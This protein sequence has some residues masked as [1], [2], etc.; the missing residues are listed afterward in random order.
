MP[1][2]FHVETQSGMAIVT[3]S[4]ELRGSD[5][6]EGVEA[7][8]KNPDWAGKSA[9]WDFRTAKF[10]ITATE[11]QELADF[12]LSNQRDTPP[13]R[14]A[15]VTGRDVDFGLARMFEAFRS[16]PRTAFRV[17]RNFD[18]ALRW[19]SAGDSNNV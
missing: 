11:V 19:A 14:V 4:G 18:K 1:V 17:F 13:E 2:S 3:C 6:M 12:V 8:W 16:D 7:L 15:F 5:A 10:I 9:V